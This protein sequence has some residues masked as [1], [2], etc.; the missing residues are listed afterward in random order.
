MFKKFIL[1]FTDRQ[2][3]QSVKL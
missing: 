3:Q 1:L 2:F